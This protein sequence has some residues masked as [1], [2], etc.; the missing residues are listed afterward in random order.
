MEKIKWRL[1]KHAFPS[2][3]R[4][5][6]HPQGRPQKNKRNPIPDITPGEAVEIKQFFPREKF[7][8]LGRARSGTI[9]LMRIG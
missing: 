9:L 5:P 3:I 1:R 2:K 6:H 4:R 8:I 7:F